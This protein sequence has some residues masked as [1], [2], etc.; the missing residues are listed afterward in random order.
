MS[1]ETKTGSSEISE[2]ITDIKEHKISEPV[3][4]KEK[5]SFAFAQMPSTFFGSVMG[6]I[7]SFYYGWMGLQNF[8]MGNAM[9]G[10]NITMGLIP[11]LVCLVGFLIWVRFYPLTGEKVN[12]MKKELREIHR[13][14]RKKYLE[15]FKDS[16]QTKKNNYEK[17]KGL[18]L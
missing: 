12:K 3:P 11:G 17:K 5:L 9:L 10:L 8:W 6:V 2:V 4:M 7:Q 14:K 13:N 16:I 1:R 15:K 18:V